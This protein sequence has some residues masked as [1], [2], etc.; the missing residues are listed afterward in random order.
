MLRLVRYEAPS[1]FLA[2]TQAT[3]ERREAVNNLILGVAVRV[4]EQPDRVKAPPYLAAV[5]DDDELA[6]AAVMTPPHRVIVYSQGE[7]DPRPLRLILEDLRTGGWNPPGVVGPSG[8]ARLFAELWAASGRPYRPGMRQRVYELR[9]V[10][11]SAPVPGHLRPA[12]PDEGPM[13]ADW[14]WGFM[15]DARLP[16]TREEA[17]SIA[18]LRI[19][20]GDIFLWDDGRP[21]SM[22]AKTR[23]STNGIVLSLVYTPSEYRNRG[24]AS[25]C[26]AALSQ[27]LLDAGW[28]FCALFTDLSNPTSN[29]IYQRIGYEPVA[30]FSEFD[31]EGNTSP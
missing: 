3:L 15:Q 7:D 23:H 22:A 29:D 16:G 26:V 30:D 18:D 28:H 21:V 12:G 14:V 25:A 1:A 27:R 17:R 10:I 6:A 31:F 13:V 11:P 5:V 24:Y 2:R 20:D 4:A 8:P 19:G 9:R